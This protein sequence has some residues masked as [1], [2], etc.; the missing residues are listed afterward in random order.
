MFVNSI[1]SVV[2][3]KVRQSHNT[4][5]NIQ[6]I[7][8]LLYPLHYRQVKRQEESVCFF[9][10][11]AAE[12][13]DPTGT[14]SQKIKQTENKTKLGNIHSQSPTEDQLKR[15]LL[16]RKGRNHLETGRKDGVARGA[17][18]AATDSRPR[19]EEGY[20]SWSWGVS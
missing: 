5:F 1:K 3:L 11:M 20:L 15:V 10:Q 13:A 7:M 18:P 19:G 2:N 4:T 17:V 9:P 14:S 12:Q 8:F 6:V 16:T